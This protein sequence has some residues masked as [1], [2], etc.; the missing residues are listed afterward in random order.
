M[1]CLTD[2]AA[3]LVGEIRNIG[4]DAMGEHK[5]IED[6]AL[7]KLDVMSNKSPCFLAKRHERHVIFGNDMES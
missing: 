2:H 1:D 5:E 7:Q 4:W 6:N 3:A